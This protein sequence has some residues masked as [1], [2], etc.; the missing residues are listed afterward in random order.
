M[1]GISSFLYSIV[2]IPGIFSLQ[3]THFYLKKDNED[4]KKCLATQVD[5]YAS[6]LTCMFVMCNFFVFILNCYNTWN[7]LTARYSFLSEKDNEDQKKCLATQ[8]DHYASRL[9][10]MFVMCNFFVFI[11]N[12]YNTW[13]LLTAM[14]SFLSEKDNEDQKKCLATQ[15]DHY[16][17]RLTCMFVM[18]NFFVFILNCYNTWNL[19]T[20]RYSFLSEKD[21]EDQKKCLATQVDQYASRLTCMFVMCNYIHGTYDTF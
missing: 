6:R 5:H 1:L 10:C 17:S 4:Q 3:G 7:L 16:A 9:T 15:V 11:L 21:N 12:C 20:A 13:N 18:C 14:Y 2:I 8:V 19:L